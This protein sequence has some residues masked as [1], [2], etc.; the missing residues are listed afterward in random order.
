MVVT[1]LLVAECAQLTDGVVRADACEHGDESDEGEFAHQAPTRRRSNEK[2]A[3]A[4]QTSASAA[5]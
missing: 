4:M 1:F 2:R 3:S 5:K